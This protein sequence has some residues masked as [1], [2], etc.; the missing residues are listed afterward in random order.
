M[1]FHVEFIPERF[2]EKVILFHGYKRMTCWQENPIYSSH[3][4]ERTAIAHEKFWN[5]CIVN[6]GGKKESEIF[7]WPAGEPRELAWCIIMQAAWYLF[8][9]PSFSLHSM[10]LRGREIRYRFVIPVIWFILRIVWLAV[11]FPDLPQPVPRNLCIISLHCWLRS[12]SLLCSTERLAEKT[13]E[14]SGPEDFRKNVHFFK[15][16]WTIFF[17]Q[18]HIHCYKIFCPW[19][20]VFAGSMKSSVI[21]SIIC[22]QHA[23]QPFQARHAANSHFLPYLTTKNIF[24]STFTAMHHVEQKPRSQFFALAHP[25]AFFV[26]Q[27]SPQFSR[28]CTHRWTFFS[29]TVERRRFPELQRF[30]LEQLWWLVSSPAFVFV[31]LRVTKNFP[32][33]SN[34]WISWAIT[35][36]CFA[37]FQGQDREKRLHNCF[38][39][40]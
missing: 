13:N 2:S 29:G 32:F 7:C 17:L 34:G 24:V 22:F 5:S 10:T 37:D 33:P 9:S 19:T 35:I 38:F 26:I 20:S 18:F 39:N 21:Q 30:E 27:C 36:P 31:G 16:I 4:H 23:S 40:H 6:V 3:P 12:A 1:N 28:N 25:H 11:N 14:L 15:S 8:P